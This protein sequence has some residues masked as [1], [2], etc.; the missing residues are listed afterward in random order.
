MKPSPIMPARRRHAGETFGKLTLIERVASTRWI[1]LCKCGAV[2]ERDT[3][4]MPMVVKRGHTPCCDGCSRKAKGENGR[5]RR[6]HGLSKTPLYHVHRQM[7][8]RCNDPAHPDY[9]G[10][11][12]RGIKVDPAF[13]DVAEFITWAN[14]NGYE[15][16]LML[17]R[18]DNDGPYSPANCRWATATE[19]ANNRR[20][21]AR[22]VA[23]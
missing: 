18:A 19:Q 22:K 23:A 17:E 2:E 6:T 8:L 10:W 13:R 16:G 5:Q 15:R 11:G 7:C 21:R 20:P 1:V 12:A 4:D 9:P 14:N 3:R